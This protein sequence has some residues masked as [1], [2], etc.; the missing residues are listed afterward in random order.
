[1]RKKDFI[2]RYL[3]DKAG[4]S[5]EEKNARSMALAT[6][7][8][9]QGK[10][11]QATRL[12]AYNHALNQN[13]PVQPAKKAAKASGGVK[14]KVRVWKNNKV[15]KTLSVDSDAEKEVVSK[16]AALGIPWDKATVHDPK[17]MKQTVKFKNA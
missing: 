2:E 11:T 10:Q 14:W 6:E 8:L 9:L 16:V 4:R 13:R 15:V 5:W 12:F 3:L 1:M 17:T 7:R